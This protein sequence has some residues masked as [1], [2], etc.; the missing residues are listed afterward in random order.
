MSGGVFSGGCLC[1][2]CRFEIDG[3]LEPAG[4][5]YCEDCRRVTGTAFGVSFRVSAAR[6]HLTEK[7]SSFAKTADSGVV[8]TR[9]FCGTCGSPLF[10][11]S[12]AHPDA[13]FV[14]AGLL[15]D[16]S[17][18]HIE[19]EAWTASRVQWAERPAAVM[20]YEKGRI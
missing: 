19:R 10:T 12:E 1:G 8:L 11:A 15:D 17:A 9:H 13:I 2:A 16:P 7:T 6:F 20:S 5:C 14:K 4:I 18:I 3:P